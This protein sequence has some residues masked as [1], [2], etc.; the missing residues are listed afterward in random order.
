MYVEPV[1]HGNVRLVKIGHTTDSVEARMRQL[2]SSCKGLTF[3]IA[4]QSSPRRVRH[5]YKRIE[6]LAHAR[7]RELQVQLRMYVQ[8]S[9]RGTSTIDEATAREVVKR[10]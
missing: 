6:T 7:T 3:R 9:I 1:M 2:A 4:D 5:Y 10:C 8:E